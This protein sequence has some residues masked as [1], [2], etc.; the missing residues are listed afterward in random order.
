MG[1]RRPVPHDNRKSQYHSDTYATWHAQRKATYRM[2]YSLFSYF[3]KSISK[4]TEYFFKKFCV[5][6]WKILRIFRKIS[7]IIPEIFDNCLRKFQ[8]IFGKKSE[9][10]ER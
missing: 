3:Q 2:R 4:D 10:F 7:K 1:T 6:F 5:I 9:N 8:E